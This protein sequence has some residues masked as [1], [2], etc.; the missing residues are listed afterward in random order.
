MKSEAFPER[1]RD[2]PKFDGPFEAM[3]LAAEDGCEVLFA[4]YPAGTSIAS[5]Q[6]DTDNHGV[7]TKGELYLTLDGVESRFGIGDWYHVAAGQKHSAR[8]ET[9]TAEIEFWFTAKP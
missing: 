6:H 7:I 2:L 5:H 1:I 8:F 4:S 3:R 9:E